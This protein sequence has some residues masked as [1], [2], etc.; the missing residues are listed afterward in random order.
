MDENVATMLKKN[1]KIRTEEIM[2][3]NY[4]P[5]AELFEGEDDGEEGDRTS[6]F[7]LAF[8]YQAKFRYTHRCFPFVGS[9]LKLTLCAF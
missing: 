1:I 4:D 6:R 9:R 3:P 7:I 8:G 2:N 5:N